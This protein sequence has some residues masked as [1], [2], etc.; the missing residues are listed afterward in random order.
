[1]TCVATNAPAQGRLARA[2]PG[3][4]AASPLVA[5]LAVYGVALA[6][7]LVVQLPLL[8]LDR[9]DEVFYV[10]VAHLWTKGVLPYAGAFDV[11]PPGFFAL[12][13]ASQLVFGPSPASVRAVAI[14]LDAVTATALFF[15]GRFVAP[16]VGLFAAIAY[17]PLSELVSFNDFYS[18]LAASTTLAFL[19]AL[20]PLRLAG[21]AA[22]TGLAVG[23]AFCIKQTAAFEALVLFFTIVGALD[24]AGRRTTAA[25]AF[26]SGASIVP[27]GFLAYFAWHGA[28]QAL[29]DDAVF[30]ALMRP[31]SPEE[32]LTFIDGVLA[33]P[34]VAPQ[35]PRADRGG[36][37]RVAPPS[38]ACRGLARRAARGSRSLAACGSVRDPG[39]AVVARRLCRPDVGA[40]AAAGGPL[41]GPRDPGIWSRARTGRGWASS[42]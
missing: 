17:P 41:R 24:A 1:M 4:L 42:P 16:R 15:L 34:S 2:L 30:G 37:P 40:G 26:V 31:A 10:E 12:V 27:F 33:L 14:A 18:A 23:A 11:K 35:H 7:T 22:L 3:R 9:I 19:A 32:G 38:R 21:R 8:H 36:L 5:L 28:A 39:A 29:I 6:W 20:S 25:L 13:A